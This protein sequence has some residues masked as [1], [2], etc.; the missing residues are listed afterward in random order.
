MSSILAQIEMLEG[1]I[2]HNQDRLTD[3]KRN[4]AELRRQYANEQKLVE[5][6]TKRQFLSE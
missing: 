3:L 4:L 1:D 2:A 6:D 5:H